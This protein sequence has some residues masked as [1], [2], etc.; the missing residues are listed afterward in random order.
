MSCP[1]VLFCVN[2]GRNTSNTIYWD[3]V[4]VFRLTSHDVHKGPPGNSES[5][6]DKSLKPVSKFSLRG[7]TQV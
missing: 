3:N 6:E 2:I 7:A 1:F 5:I 4:V